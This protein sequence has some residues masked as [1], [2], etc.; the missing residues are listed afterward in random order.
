M[1]FTKKIFFLVL[2]LTLQGII[3]ATKF[4]SKGYIID[5]DAV[6]HKGYI[7]FFKFEFTPDKIYFSEKRSGSFTPFTPADLLEFEYEGQKFISANVEL[8]TSSNN[9]QTLSDH[10]EFDL[11]QKKVFLEVLYQGTKNLYL[12]RNPVTSSKNLY[13]VGDLSSPVL[14]KRKLYIYSQDNKKYKKENST[15][16]PQL[17]EYFDLFSHDILNTNQIQYTL[18]DISKLFIKF[19]KIYPDQLSYR[20]TYRKKKQVWYGFAGGEL[21]DFHNFENEF[22]RSIIKTQNVNVPLIGVGHAFTSLNHLW[23]TNLEAYYSG[24]VSYESYH[25]DRKNEEYYDESYQKGKYHSISLAYYFQAP[26]KLP[27]G[28]CFFNLGFYG[29]IN[30]YTEFS[31]YYHQRFY[32]TEVTTSGKYEHQ[33]VGLLLGTGIQKG[34]ISAGLRYL[35]GSGFEYND[36]PFVQKIQLL[37]AYQ[38]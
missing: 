19:Y 27:F 28:G 16:V 8:E 20:T 9:I 33:E 11:I 4:E 10:R 3:R 1:V 18:H 2:I 13:F 31:S 26:Y 25:L 29:N 30:L 22:N 7:H 14:L 35:R 34:R 15:C 23:T 12:Y 21:N 17:A 38:L 32:S 6:M 5:K 37:L 24:T 36:R